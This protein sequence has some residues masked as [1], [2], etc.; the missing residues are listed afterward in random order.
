MMER[1]SDASAQPNQ[2]AAS[3]TEEQLAQVAQAAIAHWQSLGP[4]AQQ[5]SALA[6]LQFSIRDLPG[7]LLGLTRSGQIT[8]D[9]NAAGSGWFV[10]PT[11]NTNTEFGLMIGM[12]FR[13]TDP[14]ISSEMDLLTAINHE[15]GHLLGADDLSQGTD[16]TALMAPML[17][18]GTRKAVDQSVLDQLFSGSDLAEAL[19][20][21]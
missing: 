11:P 18:A 7:D 13:S 19:L 6:N 12:S 20:A 17:A 21:G 5:Q 8:L 15:L 16:S 9:V 2:A 10:D 3:L 1:R 14:G 4:S